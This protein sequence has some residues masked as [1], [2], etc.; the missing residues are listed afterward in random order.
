MFCPAQPKLWLFRE[1][2]ETEPFIL[3][4]RTKYSLKTPGKSPPSFGQCFP[5]LMQSIKDFTVAPRQ[6]LRSSPKVEV[7]NAPTEMVD[8]IH[9]NPGKCVENP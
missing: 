4:S 3:V 5:S 8:V 2:H 1:N 6:V 9:E 7:L